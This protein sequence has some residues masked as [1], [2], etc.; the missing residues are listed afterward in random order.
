M[1]ES[2]PSNAA[3][4]VVVD[5]EA[6]VRALLEGYLTMA[7]YRVS[8]CA[9]GAAFWTVLDEGGVDLV[10]LDIRLPGEDGLSIARKLQSFSDVGIIF[11][12]GLG[13]VV[14]RVAGLELGGDDYVAK[15]FDR[16]ELLARIHAVLRRRKQTSGLPLLD[17]RLDAL[18][19]KLDGVKGA[20]DKV[21]SETHHIED[22]VGTGRPVNC[23]Q[24]G[25]PIIW[26]RADAGELGICDAC[27]WS[28]FVP[29]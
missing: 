3:H 13:E 23:P 26:R 14:D 11:I 27:G 10:L 4:I 15:P 24:C 25:S 12:T 16:R 8:L 2:L 20:I 7:G 21:E 6:G 9:D 22:A 17:K 19:A 1:G 18:S 28:Q 5:D 29:K